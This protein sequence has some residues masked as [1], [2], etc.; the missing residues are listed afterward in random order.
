VTGGQ[1]DRVTFCGRA[2]PP[3]PPGVCAIATQD[4]EL[5]VLP[6]EAKVRSPCNE[7]GARGVSHGRRHFGQPVLTD[8]DPRQLTA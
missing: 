5:L 7:N 8:V 3:A 2:F 1:R 4:T 6:P